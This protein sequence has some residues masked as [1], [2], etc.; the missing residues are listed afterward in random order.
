MFFSNGVTTH[1]LFSARILSSSSAIL[2]RQSKKAVLEKD[3][4]KI[5]DVVEKQR[6]EIGRLTGMVAD[7]RLQADR[8][9]ATKPENKRK[10]RSAHPAAQAPRPQGSREPWSWD[11]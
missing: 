10:L 2:R 6:A 7:N 5:R 11:P 3:L 9:S 4:E 1:L 8:E